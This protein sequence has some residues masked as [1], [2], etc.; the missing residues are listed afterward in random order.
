[1]ATPAYLT[2]EGQKQGL[3]SSGAFTMESVGNIYQEGH[4]DEILVQAFD[5]QVSIPTDVQSGTTSGPRRHGALTITK[6]FD[7]AS[8]LIY[9]ALCNGETLTTCEIKWYRTNYDGHEEHYYTTKIVDAKIVNVKSY[10]HNCQDPS[11]ASFTHLESVSFSYRKI[12]WTHEV[13]GTSG[14]D[15]WRTPRTS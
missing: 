6:V 5:H 9:Q 15:D 12:E 7:K 14:D 11:M 3:I 1:M 10:M 4:E 13:S 8:P 2:I